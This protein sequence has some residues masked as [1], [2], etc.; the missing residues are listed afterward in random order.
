MTT[1]A[2]PIQSLI[3]AVNDASL[4]AHSRN[5]QALTASLT[6][7]LTVSGLTRLA[8]R[9]DEATNAAE[10]RTACATVAASLIAIR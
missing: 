8:A 7:R 1:T 3:I 10:F 4:G 5:Y 2:A 6:A 9:L